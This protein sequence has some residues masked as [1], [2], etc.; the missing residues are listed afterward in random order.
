MNDL[1]VGE[2]F[3]SLA[4]GTEPALGLD[5]S[6]AMQQ[7]QRSVRRTRLGVVSA[8]AAAVLVVALGTYGVNHASQTAPSATPVIEPFRV[9]VSSGPA[10]A[11][12]ILAAVRSAVPRAHVAIDGGQLVQEWSGWTWLSAKYE[13]RQGGHTSLL[14]VEVTDPASACAIVATGETCQTKGVETEIRSMSARAGLPAQIAA[15]DSGVLVRS[16]T[17]AGNPPTVLQGLT[18]L[19]L[20]KAVK[21]ALPQIA[22][23]PAAGPSGTQLTAAETE[24]EAT[25]WLAIYGAYAWPVDTPY[26][27]DSRVPARV[28]FRPPGGGSIQIYVAD[29]HQRQKVPPIPV[30]AVGARSGGNLEVVATGGVLDRNQVQELADLLAGPPPSASPTPSAS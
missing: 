2:H 19:V 6:R 7:A 10:F 9:D 15:A 21:A 23:N 5:A 11:Q 16:V 25:R 24:T 8:A 14:Y 17:S 22:L 3:G 13:I 29:P 27:N 18:A 20:A 1:D 4:A 26:S 30:G 12:S 28:L